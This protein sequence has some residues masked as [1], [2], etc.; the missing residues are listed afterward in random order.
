MKL[1]NDTH[2]KDPYMMLRKFAAV[3]ALLLP[4]LAGAASKDSLPVAAPALSFSDAQGPTY[5]LDSLKGQVVVMSY[6]FTDCAPCVQEV[7]ILNR[8]VD[9][10]AG[11]KVL[12]LAPAFDSKEKVATFL[13][14]H[15]LKYKTIFAADDRLTDIFPN[16][17][18]MFPLHV[19]VSKDGKIVYRKPGTADLT[20]ISLAIESA[21]AQDGGR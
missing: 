2:F 11:R 18:I 5:T 21:L 10:F 3:A 9:K 1:L 19:I 17:N 13:K 12:F 20:E 7:P 15:P 6:W 8:I 16:G 4:L 14:T